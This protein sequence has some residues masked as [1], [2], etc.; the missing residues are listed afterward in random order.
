MSLATRRLDLSDPDS[1]AFFHLTMT[2]IAALFFVGS[3]I[4][5][6]LTQTRVPLGQIAVRLLLLTVLLALAGFYRWRRLGRAVNLIMMAFW[7]ITF[8][9][10]HIVPMFIA[11]RVNV[12]LS[13]SLLAHI[14]KAIGLEVPQVL[15]FAGN[16]P[17]ITAVLNASYNILLLLVVLAIMLPP[18]CGKMRIAKEYA[19]GS[20]VAAMIAL[21]LFA[22]FQALGPWTYYD[23]APNAGQEEYIKTFSALKVEV[24]PT[25]DFG[26]HNGL[27][28]FP[29]F[30]AVLAILAGVALCQFS[31]IRWPALILSS[32]I[33]ISTV[34]TGWH[35]LADVLG[36]LGV[37]G[38]SMA[39]AKAYSRLE[40]RFSP[41]NV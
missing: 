20:L 7:G 41:P 27:I 40:R 19:I 9:Y 32:L 24:S 33:V 22:M 25:I 38:V 39:A 26:Y 31:Y 16:H 13:D 2:A 29:S 8:G 12:P 18:V 10:L 15:E 37:A 23:F 30:H 35:Y 6:Y 21:P 28:T 36:G 5:L 17:K 4:G 1:H 11:A 3:A 14:D 34:T